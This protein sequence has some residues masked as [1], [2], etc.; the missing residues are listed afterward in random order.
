M[1]DGD[2][3][4][5]YPKQEEF[6]DEGYCLF[7]NAKNVTDK[8]FNFETKMFISK[9]KDE[10]LKKGKL[11]RGD[12]VLT[13]RGTVGNVAFYSDNVPFDNIRINS[14]MLI[15][16]SE[17]DL[18]NE[19]LYYVLNSNFFKQQIYTFKSGTAQPQLPKSHSV[20]TYHGVRLIKCHRVRYRKHL[21][22][23]SYSMA[24]LVRN[25]T[26]VLRCNFSIQFAVFGVAHS[27][28]DVDVLN[29]ILNRTGICP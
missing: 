11:Q 12:V 13:T 17:K 10:I 25:R 8:G 3:G 18:L 4:K 5:N 1:I 21:P 16:R 19:F 26:D 28:F 2:C 27:T 14:G 7:L 20:Q 24:G 15:L 29:H 9:E 6:L 23:K 22:L